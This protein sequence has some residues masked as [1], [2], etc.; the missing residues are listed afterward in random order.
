MSAL[1]TSFA[2][3]LSLAES[4]PGSGTNEELLAANYGRA[5]FHALVE[6]SSGINPAED[7]GMLMKMTSQ[8]SCLQ[9]PPEQLALRTR[10]ISVEVWSRC[11]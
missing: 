6:C 7:G 11:I 8:K 9:S 10:L 5:A 3:K 4:I 2:T 1:F